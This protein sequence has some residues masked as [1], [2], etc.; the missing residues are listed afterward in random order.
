MNYDTPISSEPIHASMSQLS[1]PGSY[2]LA[3]SYSEALLMDPVT[4]RNDETERNWQTQGET[5]IATDII[6]SYSEAL[7]YER[8]K[9]FDHRNMMANS[10]VVVSANDAL[11]ITCND[12]NPNNRQILP[13]IPCECHC[14][15]PCHENTN[16]YKMKIN[17]RSYIE[18]ATG[19][20]HVLDHVPTRKNNAREVSDIFENELATLRTTADGRLRPPETANLRSMNDLRT[21][22]SP[23][24]CGSCGRMSTSTQTINSYAFSR[25][26]VRN[27][28]SESSQTLSKDFALGA[29][30]KNE[31]EIMPRD[32]SE[33]NLKTRTE[34]MNAFLP[35]ENVRSLENILENEKDPTRS[36]RVDAATD[37]AEIS[38]SRTSNTTEQQKRL[39]TNLPPVVHRRSP[40]ADE[41]SYSIRNASKGAI[42]KTELRN[43]RITV[44]PMSNEAC[45]KLPNSKTYLCLKS[46]LK[47]NKRRYTLVTADEFQNLADQDANR[48]FEHGLD[49]D[50]KSDCNT[51]LMDNRSRFA[52]RLNSRRRLPSFEEFVSARDKMHAFSDHRR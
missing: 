3:P 40:F 38:A 41:A 32:I 50:V 11:T 10:A 18:N 43:N 24:R 12:H 9:Q 37:A 35:R 39:P 47:Q 17:E 48:G 28:P 22:A 26:S 2:M 6:P 45:W 13:L 34:S 25:A 31:R 42:P 23:S 21:E 29:I 49:T 1:Q 51:H 8:A 27:R 19:T 14:P 4:S 15:C 16:C 20:D 33:P 7:L 46:M 5:D 30:S 36:N 52:E 44:N